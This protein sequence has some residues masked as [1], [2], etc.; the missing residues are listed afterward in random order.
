MISPADL[1][2]AVASYY[3]REVAA[4]GNPGGYP[5]IL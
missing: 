5:G 2:E 3:R 1:D 4:G